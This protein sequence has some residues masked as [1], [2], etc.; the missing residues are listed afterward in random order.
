M[1][2]KDNLTDKVN[3][4]LLEQP[5][6]EGLSAIPGI[7]GCTALSYILGLSSCISKVH[8]ALPSG[9]NLGFHLASGAGLYGGYTNNKNKRV[10]TIIA[11]AGSFAPEIIDLTQHGDLNRLGA[12]S[13]TKVVGYGVGYLIG[14]FFK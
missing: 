14:S 8:N 1:A 13:A 9:L 7:L 5:F 3:E 10:A 6:K 11:L 4:R 12:S 2:R